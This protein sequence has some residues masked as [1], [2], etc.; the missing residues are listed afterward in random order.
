MSGT[1]LTVLPAAGG[2]KSGEGPSRYSFGYSS[3]RAAVFGRVGGRKQPWAQGEGDD[4]GPGVDTEL[5]LDVVHV[6]LDRP[7]GV[8]VPPCDLAIWQPAHDQRHHFD[9]LR[10]KAESL[11][12]RRRAGLRLSQRPAAGE[13]AGG[14]E[15]DRKYRYPGRDRDQARVAQGHQAEG[16]HEG[17]GDREGILE[18][19]RG[20]LAQKSAT[21]RWRAF[22]TSSPL[23]A[24]EATPP[25]AWAILLIDESSS[26]EVE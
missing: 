8:E 12:V 22:A 19:A 14:A 6:V 21:R 16:R 10:G 2:W 18:R 23:C 7:L 1:A 26:A 13:P 3:F 11:P 4:L 9:L 24:V 15:M 20:G 17:D 25:E 5:L